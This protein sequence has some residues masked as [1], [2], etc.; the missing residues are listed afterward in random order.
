MIRG[1]EDLAPARFRIVRH[2]LLGAGL[3]GGWFERYESRT[4]VQPI[5]RK[6][7]R[8]EFV[9]RE[10]PI[11]GQQRVILGLGGGQGNAAQQKG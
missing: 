11:E 3:V 4:A 7:F 9:G 1:H 8:V 10:N 6:R 5:G 2:D